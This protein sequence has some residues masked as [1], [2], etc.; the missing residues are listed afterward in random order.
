M[1]TPKSFRVGIRRKVPYL[2]N[3]F[4]LISGFSFLVI[5][6][7]DFL[8]SPFKS[9]GQEVQSAVFFWLVPELWKKILIF[10]V[11]AF[12]VTSSAY[13]MLRYYKAAILIFY[14]NEIIIRG[15]A[16]KLTI[17][18]KTIRKVYCND[19]KNI[20]GEHKEKL[21]ITIEQKRKRKATTIRL[22][23]YNQVDE[24]MDQFIKYE[25]I[26][27]DFYNFSFNPTHMNEE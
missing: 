19:A 4:L 11:I 24:F 21:S 7:F 25:N 6:V 2:T 3:L 8:F 22:K 14:T 17:P 5:I 27:L 10:S 23:D 9:A 16:I 26:D 13:G 18:I 20:N 15:R 1:E 12:G